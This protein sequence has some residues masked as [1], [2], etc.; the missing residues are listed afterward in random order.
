MKKLNPYFVGGF[1]DAEGSFIVSIFKN[2][3]YKS[4]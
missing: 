2:I 3:K 4:G 1:T